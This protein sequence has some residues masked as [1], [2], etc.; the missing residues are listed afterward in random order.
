MAHKEM[1]WIKLIYVYLFSV[2][3]L[4]LVVIGAVQF[5]NMGLKATILSKAESVEDFREYPPIPNRLSVEKATATSVLNCTEAC[6]FSA[7]EK[8]LAQ[9]WLVEYEEYQNLPKDEVSY[10]IRQRYRTS[11]NAIAMIVVGLPLYLYHWRMAKK[12]A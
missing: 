4:V 1:H 3:G 2:I 7:E 9:E 12:S 11:A 8:Q 6:E 5:I 10:V